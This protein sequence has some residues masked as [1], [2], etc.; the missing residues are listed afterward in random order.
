VDNELQPQIPVDATKLLDYITGGIKDFEI[1]YDKTLRRYN[2]I[3]AL[4]KG[5]DTKKFNKIPGMLSDEWPPEMFRAVETIATKGFQITHTDYP[6]WMFTERLPQHEQRAMFSQKLSE[7]QADEVMMR[8]K[9]LMFWRSLALYGN[10]VI[11]HPFIRSYVTNP[12][13]SPYEGPRPDLVSMLRFGWSLGA[14]DIDD[15]SWVYKSGIVSTFDLKLWSNLPDS[16]IDPILLGRALSG[17]TS[18]GTD[19]PFNSTFV[20]ARMQL[21]GRTNIN[22]GG[23]LHE[24]V[25]WYGR[26]QDHPEN[27]PRDL[28]VF[29]LD[30]KYIIGIGWNPFPWKPYLMAKLIEV[31]EEFTAIGVGEVALRSQLALME[32]RNLMSDALKAQQYGMWMKDMYADIDNDQLEY[33]YHG[34][35]ETSRM[36]G[37]KPMRPNLEHMT[38][39]WR[40]EE[41][42]K[43]DLRQ[44]TAAAS[45]IQ[46]VA[47]SDLT[48]RES[49][50]IN[51]EATARVATLSVPVGEKLIRQYQLRANKMSCAWLDRPIMMKIT[52]MDP[53][54]LM[55]TGDMLDP[56]PML[57]LKI[58]TDLDSRPYMAKSLNEF[59][60]ITRTLP[61]A[62]QSE[63]DWRYFLQEQARMRGLDPNKFL[64][65][66]QA[67][68]AGELDNVAKAGL[69]KGLISDEM[70]ALASAG[71]PAGLPNETRLAMEQSGRSATGGGM[72]PMSDL[73]AG[74]SI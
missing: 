32:N 17:P 49:I 52:G 69:D 33:R 20:Q 28:Q 8:A 47:G 25:I 27:D 7:Y 63:I 34:V 5:T 26:A 61:E 36:E 66:K 40:R 50:L 15:A 18:Q 53:K 23:G 44:S 57:S 68:V 10:V 48:A 73:G 9:Q 24:M 39:G 31:E 65:N 21:A 14:V 12:I 3:Y 30:R 59:M 67:A 13:D 16:P 37:L 71:V 54:Y 1:E 22:R 19:S 38:L 60:G 55:I 29:V 41:I 70:R 6:N 58:A 45:T 62:V 4:Y 46:G 64:I 56:D 35:I 42:G 51:N 72:N 11:E 43:D 74:R 2:D